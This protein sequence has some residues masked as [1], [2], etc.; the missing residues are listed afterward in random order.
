MAN[1]MKMGN[2]GIKKVN[3][4]KSKKTKIIAYALPLC[5]ILLACLVMFVPGFGEEKAEISKDENVSAK[6]VYA[7]VDSADGA[8]SAPD[9]SFGGSGN[10]TPV[11]VNTEP[12]LVPESAAADKSYF[13]DAAF[14]GDSISL[15][16][17]YYN[18]SAKAL[19]NAQFFTAGSLSAANALWEVSDKSVHPS[20][21]G[22][23]MLVEDCIKNSGV[24]KVYIMLGMND[25]GLYSLDDSIENYKELVKRIKE[26]SPSVIIIVESMTPIASTSN[27]LGDKFNNT[28]IREYNSKLLEMCREMGWYFVDVGSVMYD[29][30]GY[31]RKDF[32]S[33]LE[34]MGM[35]FTN[36]GCEQWVSY[37]MTHTV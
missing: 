24:K 7:G 37:L 33:D 13:D 27:R 17:S 22:T 12:G 21:N 20:Y 16:L 35:H 23:K 2:I 11:T 4:D 3:S 9:S 5:V 14:V 26:K 30:S 28:R 19:G 18:A 8:N 31:L 1:L 34:T 10:D 15:M 32:C 6:D 29:E 36:A 25:I